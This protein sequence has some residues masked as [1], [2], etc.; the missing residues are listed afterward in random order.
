M[1][2]A[3]FQHGEAHEVAAALEGDEQPDTTALAL[4]LANALRRIHALERR[5][6]PLRNALQGVLDPFHE[7]QVTVREEASGY[8][9]AAIQAG[10]EALK[11]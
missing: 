7:G 9:Q 2:Y 3:G 8:V 4:A 10:E 11:A 6:G 5:V 1:N